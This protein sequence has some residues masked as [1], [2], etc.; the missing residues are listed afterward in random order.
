MPDRRSLIQF[1][2]Y[3]MVGAVGTVAQ[4]LVLISLVSLHWTGPVAGSVIGAVV[5]A[6]INYWLN[7]RYTFGSKAHA[8]ALPKFAATALLG[9]VVNGLLMRVLIDGVALNYLVAQ[10]ISSA[11]VL[12]VTYCINL[13]WT[14]RRRSANADA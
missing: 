10:L 11:V 1:V 4:Y 2:T 7:A 8:S 9:A 13:V 5:G 3:A 12:G 14:F 6:V